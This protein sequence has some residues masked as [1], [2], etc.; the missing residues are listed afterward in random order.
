[1]KGIDIKKAFDIEKQRHNLASQKKYNA[2]VKTYSSRH[3]IPNNNTPKKWDEKNEVISVDKKENPIAFDRYST[4]ARNIIGSDYKK[5]ANIGC[6]NG[7][8]EDFVFKKREDFEWTGLDFSKKT[9]E[10]LR[11]KYTFA[12]FIVGRAEKLQIKSSAVDCVVTLEFLEHISPKNT[13]KVLSEIKR[14]LKKG[15][16][17]ILSIPL[18]EDLEKLVLQ[19][20]NINCHVRK[21]TPE[22]IKA[23]LKIAGF[24]I[25]NVSY[26]YAFHKQYRLKTIL[27]KYRLPN[28]IIIYAKK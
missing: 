4:I 15:G 22:I 26:L 5:I 24:R 2:F 18:N 16:V 14:I 19:E 11:K 28:K 3:Q 7:I 25:D 27:K 20:K 1:M 13:F 9:I 10:R 8:L 12:K 17:Y 21:Y 6:G 23:E